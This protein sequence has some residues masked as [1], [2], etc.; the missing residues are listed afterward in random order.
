MQMNGW[1]REKTSPRS[2]SLR[3]EHVSVIIKTRQKWVGWNG[4]TSV[5]E[6]YWCRLMWKWK[7][8]PG[9]L[10]RVNLSQRPHL[11]GRAG[12]GV[13]IFWPEG[14]ILIRFLENIFL[15]GLF[16]YFPFSEIKQIVSFRISNSRCHCAN[17]HSSCRESKETFSVNWVSQRAWSS[18]P[19]LFKEST[20]LSVDSWS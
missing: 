6:R 10:Q 3:L 19:P 1:G 11:S 17:T 5:V 20:F 16:C 8:C 18:A 13:D 14:L 2:T 4:H 12:I 9:P 15:N 7:P